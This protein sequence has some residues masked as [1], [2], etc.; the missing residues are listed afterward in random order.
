MNHWFGLKG[1]VIVNHPISVQ[2][3][4]FSL[5]SRLSFSS[6]YFVLVRSYDA[7]SQGNTLLTISINLAYGFQLA[8]PPSVAAAAV[9]AAL[10]EGA[11]QWFLV[12]N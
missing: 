2:L 12:K 3:A 7:T 8:K 5:G 6:G 9:F 10:S 1:D 4:R 11:A